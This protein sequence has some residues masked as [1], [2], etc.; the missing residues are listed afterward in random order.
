MGNRSEMRLDE[1]GFETWGQDYDD[2][3]VDFQ[4]VCIKEH[5]VERRMRMGIMKK[6]RMDTVTLG[7]TYTV[8]TNVRFHHKLSE[9]QMN[10]YIIKDDNDNS[11]FMP[12]ELFASCRK[13]KLE[14]IL[15][16]L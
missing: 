11:H 7:K 10:S 4:V 16:E 8:E 13:K 14:R 15:N 5:Y 6:L 1:N 2:D 12:K 9:K 3:A